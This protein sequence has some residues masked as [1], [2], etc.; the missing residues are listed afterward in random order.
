M[1][2]QSKITE[3]EL[4][5]FTIDHFQAVDYD[6]WGERLA[7]INK[8]LLELKSPKK[9]NY[10]LVDLYA[11]YI[12]ITEITHTTMLILAQKH[13]HVLEN[14]FV[15]NAELRKFIEVDCLSR[16][17]YAWFLTN[18]GLN[19][20]ELRQRDDYDDLIGQ[21]KNFLTE[22][23]NDYMKSYNYL[24][25]FKHGFRVKSTFGGAKVSVNGLQ[26]LEADTSLT[27][28]YKE[29]VKGY[30]IVKRGNVFVPLHLN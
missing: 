7:Q 25:A 29:R 21:N 12:Q 17:F 18:Y 24:N 8:R 26:I 10:Q 16:D 4:L 22:A 6:Y 19:G 20:S 9:R 15:G 30:E 11:L 5:D 14:M 13:L 2:N 28:W 1:D 3:Q 23:A 27:Y